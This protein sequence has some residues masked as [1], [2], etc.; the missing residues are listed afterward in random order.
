MGDKKHDFTINQWDISWDYNGYTMGMMGIF[1]AYSQFI[2][3]GW[4]FQTCL[5]G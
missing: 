3:F 2:L 5:T 4:W 1:D